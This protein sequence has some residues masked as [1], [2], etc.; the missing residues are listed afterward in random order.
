MQEIK[1]INKIPYVTR[2]Q[3]KKIDRLMINSWHVGLIQM[4]ENAG[5]RLAEMTRQFM[6]GSVEGKPVLVV[7]GTGNNGGG[8]MAAARHLHNWGAHVVVK[9]IARTSQMKPVTRKQLTIL[10]AMQLKFVH[11]FDDQDPEVILDAVMGYGSKGDPTGDAKK[12][13]DLINAS[14]KPIISLD[15]PSGLDVT[16]GV[17]GKPCV[18][19][20]TTLTLALPKAGFL[21]E[22]AKPYIGQ[23]YL[24]DIG[25]PNE[26]L[27]SIGVKCT[28]CFSEKPIIKVSGKSFL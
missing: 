20:S 11:N 2:E 19:A 14:K 10:K 22:A 5:I 13:I 25:I 28:N 23:L 15:S 7:C 9:I 24:A 26:L 21:T 8:G 12:W 1:M 6:G 18:I 17:P 16:T 4:M 27:E 3:M